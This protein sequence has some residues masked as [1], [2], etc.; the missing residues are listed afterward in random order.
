MPFIVGI[1]MIWINVMIVEKSFVQDAR[2]CSLVNFAEA[3]C[4]KIVP[5][6]VDG[7]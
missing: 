3:D 4:A 5:R 2:H 6:H 7:E 1:A